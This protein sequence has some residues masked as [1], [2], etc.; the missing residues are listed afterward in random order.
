MLQEVSEYSVLQAATDGAKWRK[1]IISVKHFLQAPIYVHPLHKGPVCSV[2]LSPFPP[3]NL[4]PLH[5]LLIKY[6]VLRLKK[7]MIA[8]CSKYNFLEK[9]KLLLIK[10]DKKKK[11]LLHWD[12]LW[13]TGNWSLI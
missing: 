10:F 2:P 9:Q 1:F 4:T 6:L 7:G 5:Q 12:Q 11:K 8:T 13:I 3:V